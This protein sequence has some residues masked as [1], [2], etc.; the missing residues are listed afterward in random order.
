L[1]L[2]GAFQEMPTQ[3]GL[4]TSLQGAATAI[5]SSGK[6][7]TLAINSIVFDGDKIVVNGQDAKAVITTNQNQEIIITEDTTTTLNKSAIEQAEQLQSDILNNE[8]FDFSQLE[9]TAAGPQ[10]QPNFTSPIIIEPSDNIIEYHSNTNALSDINQRYSEPSKTPTNNSFADENNLVDQALSN[11]EQSFANVTEDFQTALQGKI[12]ADTSFIANTQTTNLGEISYDEQ[13]DWQYQLNNQLSEIQTLGAGDTLT[14]SIAITAQNGSVFFV[15]ITI[16]GSNDQASISGTTTKTITEDS[17]DKTVEVSGN[18]NIQDIDSGEA[19]FIAEDQINTTYGTAEVNIEGEWRYIL[20]NDLSSIQSL[21]S[22]SQLTDF[23]SVRSFDGTNETIQ[24]TIQGT[25]DTPFLNGTNQATLNLDTSN[26][27]SGQLEINDPDFG[28]SHFQAN[29]N[30]AGSFGTG[31]I[32]E[33]GQW[34]YQVDTNHAEISSLDSNTILHD[35]FVVTTAD[36]TEQTII[37]PI[38]NTPE[39]I[40]TASVNEYTSETL[41]IIELSDN[42]STLAPNTNQENNASSDLYIWGASNDE[43]NTTQNTDSIAQFTLGS[44][45]DILQLNDLLL[46][47]QTEDQLDQFLHFSSDGQDTTIEIN[48][49]QDTSDHHFLVLNNMDLTT[50]GN[51][52]S[53]IIHQLIQQG[54]LD[55]VGL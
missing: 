39:A 37:I 24:I 45:G 1:I 7:L 41:A 16:N 23:F 31:S 28:E 22:D 5:T 36:G 20:N 55:I 15:E 21:T 9:S 26:T 2:F 8:D 33:N 34:S 35:T 44:G 25:N 19:G 4:I 38:S 17:N 18:L 6:T 29:T 46:E 43:S 53:E 10:E 49:N 11:T 32:E 42:D 27:A 12:N 13:G 50:M 54:N 47:S 51:T 30:I 14:E 40:N 52:D 48:T 3:V